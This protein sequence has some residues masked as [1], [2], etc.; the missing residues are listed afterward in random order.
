[1]NSILLQ[2]LCSC[3][4]CL[5]APYTARMPMLC[6]RMLCN[7]TLCRPL[8]ETEQ[9]GIEACRCSIVRRIVTLFLIHF[10]IRIYN[11]LGLA[12]PNYA[13]LYCKLHCMCFIMVSKTDGMSSD[14]ERMRE[15]RG[16]SDAPS[17]FY[18]V[19]GS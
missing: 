6:D 19:D 4:L 18:N 8:L 3:T 1:M 11:N 17:K 16:S 14:V 9:C 13:A 5:K 10:S 2:L 12:C 15:E 7:I